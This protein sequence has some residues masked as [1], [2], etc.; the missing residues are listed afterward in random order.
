MA[1]KRPSMDI[2]RDLRMALLKSLLI[3]VLLLIFYLA[4]PGWLNEK[5]RSEIINAV[6]SDTDLSWSEKQADVEKFSKLD[7]EQVCLDCPPGYEKLHDRL[8]ESG[9]SAT[10]HRLRWGL[11]LSGLLVAILAVACGSI[12][13]LNTKARESQDDLIRSY[14]R[15]WA[16]AIAAALAKVFLLIPLLAYGSFEFTVMLSNSYFPKLLIVIIVG[17]IY[18]LWKSAAVLLKKVPM[19]F[20]ERLCR[21]VTP[22][23][24]P[25]LW[26]AVRDAARKLQ[27]NPPDRIL[28]GMQLNFFVTELAVVYDT[29]RAQGKTLYLS[30]PLLKQLSSDEVLAIVGHEL[31][32]F[33]GEDTRMTREFYPLRLKIHGTMVAMARSGW[34]GWPSF[35]F[36][37]FFGLCFGETERL[38]SRHRELL[39]DEKAALLTTPQIAAHALVKFQVC[40]EALK[41]GLGD[42]LKSG[43]KN[44]L[45]IPLHT[46]VQEKLASDAGFWG[47]LFEKKLPHPLDT[48]PSLQTRLEALHQT[49]DA[50]QARAVALTESE[51]AYAKWFSNRDGLFTNLAQQ[52]EAALGKMRTRTQVAQADYQTPEGKELLNQHFP[53]KKW[54]YRLTSVWLFA[55]ILGI[56]FAGCV[57][58]AILAPDDV[59]KMITALIAIVMGY[60]LVLLFG[61]HYGAVCTL[62]AEGVS[63]SA[64]KRPLRF[65][66]V[67][68]IHARR[69]SGSVQMVF[70]LKASQAAIWKLS[71]F[72]FQTRKVRFSL[73]GLDGNPI[74]IA[75]TVFRYFTRQPEPEKTLAAK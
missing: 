63:Y 10:F 26:E 39:A 37:N 62:T 14:R 35:Q 51:T 19:E 28:A 27:T 36:L 5:V 52:A 67:E 48:H 21:E 58:G 20:Q 2:R 31:G 23:D 15:G 41:R 65:S 43:A 7:F 46:I 71:L 56:I 61:R 16:I 60:G 53:E 73:T 49:I 32:H 69:S 70:R 40:V 68:N 75:Q 38:A 6:N 34:A 18:A 12:F 55:V 44:V 13:G 45:D 50:D 4:A 57:A 24:A 8:E 17:G 3:P 66:D 42:A 1:Q 25:E 72:P 33:I 9:V 59:T 29:G 11:I 64:W 30:Y 22:E 74:A 47:Q 54:R